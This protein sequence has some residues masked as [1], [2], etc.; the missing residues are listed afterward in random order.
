MTFRQR[1]RPVLLADLTHNLNST[2]DLIIT[3]P[4]LA[5]I[6]DMRKHPFAT[7]WPTDTGVWRLPS[8]Q[9]LVLQRA[10]RRLQQIYRVSG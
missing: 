1:L 4:E 7:S 3:Q 6:V 8:D 10:Q 5:V 9:A 2:L